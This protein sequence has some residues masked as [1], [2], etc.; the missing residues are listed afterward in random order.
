[1]QIPAGSTNVS[2]PIYARALSGAALTGKAAGDFTL[3]YARDNGTPVAV[4]EAAITEVGGGEYRLVF[5][6]AAFAVGSKLVTI[7][8]TV[9][10]GVVLGYPISL[11]DVR[12]EIGMDD[13]N[14]DEQL[15]ALATAIAGI[16]GGAG[17]DYKQSVTVTDGTDPIP[18]AKVRLF[19]GGLL[20]DEDTTD[21][22]GL[23][24]VYADAGVGYELRGSARG[25]AVEARTISVNADATLADLELT[26]ISISPP[27][28]PGYVTAAGLTID[29]YGQ[30]ESGVKVKFQITS[31]P[32]DAGSIL[33]TATAIYTSD[34]NGLVEATLL[35]GATYRVQ[36]G[37]G[38][39][40]EGVEIPDDVETM[41]LPEILG[42]P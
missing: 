2:V 27:T 6:D 5:P 42:R 14:M 19:S 4:D 18:N 21:E 11:T 37:N 24:D 40:T 41:W 3:V 13:A 30:V 22:N 26:E 1:M 34:D 36:R 35:A 20:I 9:D 32:G 28:E 16:S 12:A 23:A 7:A 29:Q 17:G 15:G 8:G 39:W 38:P 33:D 31:G 10:G 25:Y